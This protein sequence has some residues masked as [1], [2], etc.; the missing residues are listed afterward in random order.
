MRFNASSAIFHN[1]Q[2]LLTFISEKKN[3][4]IMQNKLCGRLHNL[5]TPTEKSL[6]QSINFSGRKRVA[7]IF[8][9]IPSKIPFLPHCDMHVKII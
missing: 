7:G 3:I 8:F 1:C 9:M 2:Q 6:Q 4:S 5:A